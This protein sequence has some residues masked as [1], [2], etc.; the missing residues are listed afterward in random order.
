MATSGD[1]LENQL[2]FEGRLPAVA[3]VQIRRLRLQHR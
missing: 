2:F 1:L 3:A